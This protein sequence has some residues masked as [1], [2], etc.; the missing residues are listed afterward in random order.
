[1]LGPV[2]EALEPT[3]GASVQTSPKHPADL[4]L[5]ADDQLAVGAIE[6]DTAV[7]EHGQA[8]EHRRGVA[9]TENAEDRAVHIGDMNI[10]GGM[11]PRDGL[12]PP[13]R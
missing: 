9:M 13:T 8:H 1:M 3:D 10:V 6:D 12:E 5:R 4:A 7:F 11:A 2:E